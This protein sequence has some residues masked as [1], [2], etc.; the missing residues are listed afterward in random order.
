[1]VQNV[2]ASIQTFVSPDVVRVLL[3][4]VLLVAGLV[5]VMGTRFTEVQKHWGYAIIGTL[6]GYWLKG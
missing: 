6:I 2:P 4:F 5:T 1:M 3:T